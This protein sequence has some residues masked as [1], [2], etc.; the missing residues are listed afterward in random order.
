MG[1]QKDEQERPRVLQYNSK[2]LPEKFQFYPPMLCELHS[3]VTLIS[4]LQEEYMYCKGGVT[5][6]SDSKPL[7][8]ICAS[9]NINVKLARIR[10]F[11]NSL[12]WLKITF[13]RG[14]SPMI[15]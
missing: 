2:V 6:Y 10:I 15:S 14:K 4:K 5:V 3:L 9:S 8:L 1:F 7:I 13:N 12:F 11:L